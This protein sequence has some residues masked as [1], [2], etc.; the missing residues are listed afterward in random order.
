MKINPRSRM[1]AATLTTSKYWPRLKLRRISGQLDKCST[2]CT[3]SRVDAVLAYLCIR[4][5]MISLWLRGSSILR[6]N[7]MHML[8]SVAAAMVGATGN[9]NALR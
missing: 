6:S 7:G 3:R 4:R 9:Q 2:K 1:Q 8:R 5:Q